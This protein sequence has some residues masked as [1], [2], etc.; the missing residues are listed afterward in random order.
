MRFAREMTVLGV[1]IGC[2]ALERAGASEP[3]RRPSRRL[4]IT[5]VTEGSRNPFED[6]VIAV[7][8]RHETGAWSS[9]GRL[10]TD[11]AYPPDH[12]DPFPCPTPK[13]DAT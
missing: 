13:A 1:L 9:A 10:R 3:G 12:C 4:S 6:A 7:A 11:P 2:L 8:T 5:V